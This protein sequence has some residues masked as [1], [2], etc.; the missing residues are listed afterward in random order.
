MGDDR[1]TND[2][3]G[4][5]RITSGWPS[6]SIPVLQLIGYLIGAA[7]IGMVAA[8]WPAWRAS[9]LNVPAA[10]AAD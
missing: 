1:R 9:R 5:C 10:I 6:L 7:L 4:T 3:S 2:T 8:V